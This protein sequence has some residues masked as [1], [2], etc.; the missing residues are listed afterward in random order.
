MM[1][2]TGKHISGMGGASRSVKRQ[3]SVFAKLGLPGAKD[4]Y[5]GTINIVTSPNNYRIDKY[6]YFFRNVVHKKFPFKRIEDFG[7]IEIFNLKHNGISYANW[8]FIYFPLNSPHFG[9]NDFFELL[10]K[11]IENI[12][13]GDEFEIQIADGMLIDLGF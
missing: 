10:G 2:I 5:N 9:K 6:D 8:G 3:K 7:F 4:F 13:N 1:N 11:K 12:N